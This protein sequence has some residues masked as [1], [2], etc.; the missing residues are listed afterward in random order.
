[1]YCVIPLCHIVRL[2]QGDPSFLLTDNSAVAIQCKKQEE[3]TSGRRS[4]SSPG[5]MKGRR[6]GSKGSKQQMRG[7][8]VGEKEAVV[9][10]W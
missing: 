1:M 8:E 3:G 4:E 6:E 7:S 9:R 5:E 2:P 10:G